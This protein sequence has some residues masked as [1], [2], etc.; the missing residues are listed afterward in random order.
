MFDAILAFFSDETI[1]SYVAIP[2][3]SGL[4]GWGTNYLAFKMIFW[5]VEFVGYRPLY[6][7]WQ[8]IVP[9]RIH[10]M[11][12][13]ACDLIT[14]KLLSIEEVFNQVDPVRVT[15]RAELEIGDGDHRTGE[16]F[17]LLQL[18][19]LREEDLRQALPDGAET[20]HR[21]LPRLHLCCSLNR[22]G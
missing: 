21:D 22:V 18:L 9:M 5:P 2:F 19:L 7:G 3:I 15:D 11:A 20:D 16:A 6:L 12:G 1:M 8:G 14:T 4:V 10:I 17:L 13:L